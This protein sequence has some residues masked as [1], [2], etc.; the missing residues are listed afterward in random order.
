MNIPG[1]ERRAYPSQLSH[2]HPHSSRP[3]QTRDI[4]AHRFLRAFRKFLSLCDHGHRTL[5][6]FAIRSFQKRQCCSH[7]ERHRASPSYISTTIGHFSDTNQYSV[8]VTA[9]RGQIF[10]QRY[11]RTAFRLIPAGTGRTPGTAGF[12]LSQHIGPMAPPLSL[13]HQIWI[14]WF[15][16][17]S[18]LPLQ[19]SARGELAGEYKGV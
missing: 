16:L 17:L 18:R 12:I 14:S 3:Q 5:D 9:T 7:Y 2:G 4:Y 6:F 11:S 15:S 19:D 10:L 13:G 8:H 1:V